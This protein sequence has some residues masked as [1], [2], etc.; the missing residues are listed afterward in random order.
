ML[1]EI[2]KFQRDK[3]KLARIEWNQLELLMEQGW[4]WIQTLRIFSL[5]VRAKWLC[6]VLGSSFPS[7]DFSMAASGKNAC[8]VFLCIL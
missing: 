3:K 8:L 1:D 6:R 2:R 5:D 7:H 4:T